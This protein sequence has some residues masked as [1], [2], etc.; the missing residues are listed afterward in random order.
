M[1]RAAFACYCHDEMAEI[2]ERT[3]AKESFIVELKL[4]Y[5]VSL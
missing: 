5:F 1:M 3:F 4:I 2:R